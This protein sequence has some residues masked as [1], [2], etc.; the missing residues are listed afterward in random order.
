M[1]TFP[2]TSAQWHEPDGIPVFEGCPVA[3]ARRLGFLPGVPNILNV[4]ARPAISAPAE[5]LERTA[6]FCADIRHGAERVAQ[7]L[8]LDP[9]HPARPWWWFF[10][11]WAEE[12]CH[13]VH[14]IGRPAVHGSLGYACTPWMLIDYRGRGLT[15][16]DLK[17]Q[18]LRRAT[19]PATYKSWGYEMAAWRLA[20]QARGTLGPFQCLTL[21]MNSQEPHLPVEAAWSEQHL[22]QCRRGFLAA[23]QLWIVENGY[24]PAAVRANG[25]RHDW[26]GRHRPGRHGRVARAAGTSVAPAPRQP[27]QA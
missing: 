8:D 7:G 6:Q 10:R 12:H 9:E 15:L 17:L 18:G 25:R 3:D 14:W 5:T 23:R 16:V 4:V 20:L 24:D 1:S 2:M 13:K 21:V 26:V 19:G 27:A 11:E 22:A